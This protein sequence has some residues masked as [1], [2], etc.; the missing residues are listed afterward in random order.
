M[1]NVL[2]F[3]LCLFFLAAHAVSAVP[4]PPTAWSGTALLTTE[5]RTY[6]GTY[7]L[8]EKLILF[9]I[10]GVAYKGYYA[11]H[12]QDDGSTTSGISSG[13]WGRA[14]LFASSAKVLRCQLET[15][16]PKVSGQCQGADGRIFRL[17]PGTLLKTS[18]S[19]KRPATK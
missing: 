15:E 5:G 18:I 4:A 10:D 13:K 6:V 1:K 12:A 2:A 9:D 16:F 17:T 19:P 8:A 3:V 11:S 7:S 14:F